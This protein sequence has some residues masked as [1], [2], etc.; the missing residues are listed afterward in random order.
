[1]SQEKFKDTRKPWFRFLKKIMR[2]FVKESKFTYLGGEKINE[3]TIILSNHVG[4]SAP[5]AFELYGKTHLRFWGAHEMNSGLVAL[6]KY[7]T[8]IFYHEKKHW[9]LHLAR[10][11]C[12]IA[13]PL[14]NMF[15]KGLE[16]ISTYHDIHFKK[17]IDESI[18]TLKNGKSI[19]I[20]PEISDKGYLDELEGF[21]HGFALLCSVLMRKGIDVPITVAYYKKNEKN[22]IIDKPVM[23]SELFVEGVSREEIAIK[24]CNRC[25][26]L[27][28]M[29]F[30]YEDSENKVAEKVA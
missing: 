19:V 17:T 26:E 23:L 15:Y 4:T 1:M 22:Y 14:T 5:L 18:E 13:S 9:N 24:L 3:P 27:G 21:H 2:I 16:L 8:R 10:L 20:F 30:E 11:F 25:N 12:L 7:Q 6:Y 29:S 28:K